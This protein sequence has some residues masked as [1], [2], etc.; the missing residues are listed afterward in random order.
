MKDLL[1]TNCYDV[2]ETLVIVGSCLPNMQP[3]AYETLQKMAPEVYEVYLEKEHL[4]MLITKIMGMLARIKVKKLVFATVDKSPHCVQ[5][6]YVAKELEKAMDLSGM[7]IV[8][9]VAVEDELV[10]IPKEVIGISKNLAELKEKLNE[11]R[12][13]Q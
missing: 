13:I 4:N 3:K 12:E 10:E 5:L 9:Y 2:L 7:E 11:K 6:H 8:N 1:K